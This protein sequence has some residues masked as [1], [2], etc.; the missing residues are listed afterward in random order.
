VV[1]VEVELSF[2]D[3]ARFI[4]HERRRA[5]FCANS[6]NGTQRRSPAPVF[7]LAQ[8][9]LA[10]KRTVHSRWRQKATALPNPP[11]PFSGPTSHS[12]HGLGQRFLAPPRPTPPGGN[13]HAL[14]RG[15]GARFASLF[16]HPYQAFETPLVCN[17]EK[18]LIISVPKVSTNT[19]HN[20]PHHSQTVQHPPRIHTYG[21][22]FFIPHTPPLR[23]NRA[24]SEAN[25]ERPRARSSIAW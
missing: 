12:R 24:I 13:F 4:R 25:A 3:L 6:L 23:Q 16:H 19:R 20:Q 10:M 7:A 1:V 17:T 15:F 14:A 18:Y 2:A 22:R 5:H 9:R 8:L 11:F 21:P